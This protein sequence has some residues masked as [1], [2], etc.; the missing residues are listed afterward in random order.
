[1]CESTKHLRNEGPDRLSD[2][3]NRP[4]GDKKKFIKKIVN[5][6]KKDRKEFPLKSA[7]KNKSRA[8]NFFDSNGEG[9]DSGES[10][11]MIFCCEIPDEDL[12]GIEEGADYVMVT[13]K[14][15]A[16]F[17]AACCVQLTG[18]WFCIDT[19]CNVDITNFLPDAISNYVETRNSGVNTAGQGGR[20]KI[21]GTYSWGDA[22]G[23]KYTVQ[24]LD[25]IC[26]HLGSSR[27]DSVI[28]YCRPD[29]QKTFVKLTVTTVHMMKTIAVEWCM[30][31]HMVA[32]GGFSLNLLKI[33]FA[34]MV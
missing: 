18:N 32:S 22:H 24:K 5:S 15:D 16:A 7:M 20:L 1:M 21:Q 28:F 11:S 10:S 27:E 9:D 14:M 6:P 34:V 13:A 29:I 8:N 4:R 31:S 12:A 19:A 2:G 30:H 25:L 26:C 23:I 3:E 33:S 17:Q